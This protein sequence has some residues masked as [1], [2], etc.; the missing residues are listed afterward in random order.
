MYFLFFRKP[1]ITFCLLSTCTYKWL[2]EAQNLLVFFLICEMGTNM[3]LT[4]CFSTDDKYSEYKKVHLRR[5][6]LRLLSVDVTTPLTPLSLNY[7]RPPTP[8]DNTNLKNPS[9]LVNQFTPFLIDSLFVN[10]CVI[11]VE[12]F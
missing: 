6:T 10:N 4:C 3:W 7:H 11:R 2:S 8:R 1:E 12:Q 9:L 5:T